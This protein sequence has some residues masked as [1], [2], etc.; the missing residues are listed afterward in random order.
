MAKIFVTGVLVALFV[1]APAA[2]GGSAGTGGTFYGGGYYPHSDLPEPRLFD[3]IGRLL[4]RPADTP[5]L[6]TVGQPAPVYGPYTTF[7]VYSGRPLYNAPPGD[8]R[9]RIV[10][11][12]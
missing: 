11:W 10:P 7:Q 4:G 2:A 8:E 6:G 12:R 9:Y 1:S 5:T 3:V